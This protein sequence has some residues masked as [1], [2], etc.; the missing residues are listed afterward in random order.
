VLSLATDQ[1]PRESHY[2]F[3]GASSGPAHGHFTLVASS[4]HTVF[5]R[6]RSAPHPSNRTDTLGA[7][8]TRGTTWRWG[9]GTSRDFCCNN[10]W[11]SLS[12]RSARS[13]LAALILP[14]G[15]LA[16]GPMRWS[17]HCF[18]WSTASV[19]SW[20]FLGFTD[21]G[22][23]SPFD[24]AHGDRHSS[25]RSHARRDEAAPSLR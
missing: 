4:I 13:D 6:I 12:S 11:Q 7:P 15:W 22:P 3:S 21:S 19:R 20:W 18:R 14:T 2:T 23:D 1:D 25:S 8:H 10:T 16:A 9:W 24:D 5:T 17:G